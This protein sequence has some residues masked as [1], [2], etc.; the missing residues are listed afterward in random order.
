[1]S[2]ASTGKPSARVIA[3]GQRAAGDD[4]V[5]LAVLA[6]LRAR[7]AAGVELLEAPTRRR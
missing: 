7:R 1:M 6:W 5:G 2:V 4:G 3:L